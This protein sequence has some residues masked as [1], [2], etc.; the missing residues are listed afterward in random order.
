MAFDRKPKSSDTLK[1]RAQGRSSSSTLGVTIARSMGT[2]SQS[3]RSTEPPPIHAPARRDHS[4]SDAASSVTGSR[5]SFASGSCHNADADM[6]SM[7]V[8]EDFEDMSLTTYI[9]TAASSDN[10]SKPQPQLAIGGKCTATII[11]TPKT[12]LTNVKITGVFVE[13]VLITDECGNRQ[14]DMQHHHGMRLSKVANHVPRGVPVQAMVEIDTAGSVLSADAEMDF[15]KV[16]HRVCVSV[17]YEKKRLWG[18]VR[19]GDVGLP[20]EHDLW[21]V[22]SKS[23]QREDGL[24]EVRVRAPLI[25]RKTG[26]D[27]NDRQCKVP[28]LPV[29][30]STG[31]VDGVGKSEAR[32]A[33]RRPSWALQVSARDG[34]C[35][36]E[37]DS[38]I[39][40]LRELAYA[41]GGARRRANSPDGKEEQ[42][43]QRFP[44]FEADGEL[45]ERNCPVCLE[46][47]SEGM[48]MMLPCMHAGHRVC[49]VRSQNRRLMCPVCRLDLSPFVSGDGEGASVDQVVEETEGFGS[50][51]AT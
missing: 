14:V 45:A 20:C 19:F 24:K 50:E 31:G 49:L 26:L 28:V 43:L 9:H 42:R 8:T 13:N 29:W 48:V 51:V 10:G 23:G 32:G 39:D 40:A 33:R 36:T 6:Q 11:I 38:K 21:D 3:G 7:A 30:G 22:V 27:G 41:K 17:T 18:G 16:R 4:F 5:W 25:L 37:N 47:L 34:S 46:S 15:T 2:L 35:C 12:G 1:R 44:T